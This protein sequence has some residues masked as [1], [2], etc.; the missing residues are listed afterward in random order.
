M[1]GLGD[2]TE[3]D[4]IADG[5]YSTF[6]TARNLAPTRNV[7]GC[8]H[9]PNGPVDPLA[10]AGWGNCLL[11]NRNRRIG[12]QSARSQES[13]GSG[14]PVPQGPYD[15]QALLAIMCSVN[16][17]VFELD[18]RSSDQ[19]FTHVAELL[20]SAFIIARELSHPR[21]NSGCPKHPG[22]PLD[23]D[24]PGGPRCLFCRAQELR[25]ASGDVPVMV[26]R[27]KEIRARGIRRKG[28][29]PYGAVNET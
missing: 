24:V 9:H 2:P 19:E 5:L 23:V 11:C 14:Y 18:Y 15:H 7:T 27:S 1:D 3:Y 20:H 12:N 6:S 22:A 28:L 25:E 29:R 26:P 13:A 16:E 17:C 10:P 21:S 8:P 4:R